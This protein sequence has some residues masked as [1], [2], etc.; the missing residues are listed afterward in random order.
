MQLRV[1][2]TISQH[3]RGDRD[4]KLHPSSAFKVVLVGVTGRRTTIFSNDQYDPW[5]TTINGTREQ[6]LNE[7]MKAAEN[8]AK[9]LGAAEIV[10]VQITRHEVEANELRER[11]AKDTERLAELEELIR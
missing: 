8:M 7:A 11:I 10:G 1:Y 2:E 6:Y 5:W 4:T 3:P 9:T